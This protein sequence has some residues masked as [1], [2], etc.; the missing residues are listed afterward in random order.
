MSRLLVPICWSYELSILEDIIL[1]NLLKFTVAIVDIIAVMTG[2]TT[3]IFLMENQK[4]GTVDIAI[5]SNLTNRIRT[6][7]VNIGNTNVPF[8]NGL[9][10]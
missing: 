4:I 1:W 9:M 10:T 2:V 5:L 6:M 3:V 8:L 7:I